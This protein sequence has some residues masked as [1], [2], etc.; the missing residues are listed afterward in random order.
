MKLTLMILSTSALVA[1]GQDYTFSVFATR[2]ALATDVAVDSAGNVY[3]ADREGATVR[4]LTPVGPSYV[5]TTIAGLFATFGY[6]DGTNNDS[7]FPNDSVSGVPVDSAGN[8]YAM[9]RLDNVIR[10][11]TPVGTNY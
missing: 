1:C 4:K 11:I 2:F 8:V 6:V 10:K 5:V 7:R 3:V 9:D